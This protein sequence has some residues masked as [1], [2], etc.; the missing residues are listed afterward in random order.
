MSSLSN[1]R[2]K[3]IA[4]LAKKK[5]RDRLGQMLIEGVRS[6]EAAVEAGAPLVEIL[7]TD[8]VQAEARVQALLQEAQVP[9][10]ILPEREL[11]KL[12]EVQTSQ[13]VLAVA[14]IDLLPEER[15]GTCQTIL[16]LDGVQ[17][18]GNVGTLIRTAAWFGTDAVL[19]GPGTAD[20]FNPKV[21]R[22]AMG[23]LWDVPLAQTDD[24]EVS[25]RNL[26]ASGFSCY[27]ADLE[28][29]PATAWIPRQPSVLV[30]GSEAHGLSSGV[31]ALL[32]ERV[33][34]RGTPRR[35]GTESLNVAIAGGILVYAWL[36]K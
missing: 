32:D 21:V 1:R 7:V 15:L 20:V 9:V 14:R 34:I 28:G 12:S 36:G 19:A 29:T 17:D 27:G 26:Q 6:V 31:A 13:G 8:A 23:G 25:L 18:P 3:E 4:S 33:A 22:A 16:A 11:G 35:E 24:L 2:S 10:Y 30:L 5:Y